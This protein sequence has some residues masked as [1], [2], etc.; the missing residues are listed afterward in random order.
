MSK[1]VIAVDIDD[2]IAVNVPAFIEFSNAKWGTNL[3]IEDYDEHWVKV[4]NLDQDEAEKRAQEFHDSDIFMDYEHMPDARSVL[5]KLSDKYRLVVITARRVQLEK[6]TLAWIDKYFP[7]LFEEIV[8]AGIW[9]QKN[10]ERHKQTKASICRDL[11]VDYLI[12]DQFKHCLAVAEDE[13]KSLLFGEYPWNRITK[14]IENVT[15]FKNWQ[16]VLEF[17][18]AQG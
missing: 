6:D 5:E 18:D 12:D 2:V 10:T 8:F 14:E 3:T 4:W 11:K 13:M 1:K 17:L 15:R 9:D 16:D 7:N